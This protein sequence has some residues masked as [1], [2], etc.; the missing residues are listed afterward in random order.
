MSAL[1]RLAYFE[2]WVDRQPSSAYRAGPTWCGCA[3]T[4]RIGLV[5]KLMRRPQPVDRF[6]LLGND[7]KGKTLGVIGLGAIGTRLAELCNGLFGMTVLAYDPYLSTA[8][9]L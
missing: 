1:S 3:M 5:D 9:H 4:I 8:S 2:G 7:I 6:E